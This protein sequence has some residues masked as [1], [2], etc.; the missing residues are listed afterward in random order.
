M[1]KEVQMPPPLLLGVTRLQARDIALRAAE[2]RAAREIDPQIQ[3]LGRRIELDRSDLP[4]LSQTERRLEQSEILSWHPEAP[5]ID[6]Q[7]PPGNQP[8]RTATHPD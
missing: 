2:R 1:P 4:R 6:D 3:P 5:I 8:P 7:S